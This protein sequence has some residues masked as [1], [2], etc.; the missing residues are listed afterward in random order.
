MSGPGQSPVRPKNIKLGPNWVQNQRFGLKICPN[1]SY[2]LPGPI[3]TT[4]RTQDGVPDPIFPPPARRSRAINVSPSS[5]CVQ[6][7]QPD[8]ATLQY[9]EAGQ[10][11]FSNS[12]RSLFSLSFLVSSTFEAKIDGRLPVR[13]NPGSEDFRFGR[14]PVRRTPGSPELWS[15][16][17][18]TADPQNQESA[19]PGPE[20]SAELGLRGTG[21]A[22]QGF[23]GTGSVPIGKDAVNC[24]D[25]LTTD[26]LRM[27]L[28]WPNKQPCSSTLSPLTT[29]FIDAFAR[30]AGNC[31]FVFRYWELV[32]SGEE[33]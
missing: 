12:V 29:M 32:C 7:T 15:A 26:V 16:L 21:T 1:E 10:D 20:E 2:G 5:L 13:R 17:P 11:V 14:I 28:G 6:A 18:I 3:R 22:E 19:E 9:Y 25:V 27:A 8:Q 24:F 30:S 23:R 4:P 33:N 31:G